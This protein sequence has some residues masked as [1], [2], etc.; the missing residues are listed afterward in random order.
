MKS[1]MGGIQRMFLRDK[2]MGISNNGELPEKLE[3]NIVEWTTLFLRN[4]NIYVKF[5]LGIPLNQYQRSALHDIGVSDT[6]FWRAARNGAKSFITGLA[7]ICKLMLYPNCW[8][9]VTAST[10]DQANKIVEDKIE[11]EIIKKLSP[12]LSYWLAKGWIKITKPTDGFRVENLLNNSVLNVMGPVPSSR[13]SRSNF[14]IYDEIATMKKADVDQIFEGMLY[15]RQPNYLVNNPK[16]MGNKRWL[17]ESKAIYLTSSRYKHQWWYGLWKD[18]VSGYYTDKKSKYN[19]FATDYFD[20]IENGLKTWGDFRRA[21]RTMNDFDFRMEM[22]NEAIGEAQDAF[23]SLKFFTDNQQL[24]E[25]FNPLSVADIYAGKPLSMPQKEAN[26]KRLVIA[27]LAFAGNSSY[28][29][30]DHTVFMCMSLHWK[31]FRFERHIDYIETRPGGGADK[32]VLRLKELFWQYQ[33]DYLIYDNKS[34]GETIYDYLSSKTSHP[35]LGVNWNDSGFT[36]CNESDIQIAREGK[37]EELRGRTVDKN[38]VP[39]LIPI[40]ATSEL[41]SLGWQNLRK[42]LEVN[43]IKF[44]LSMQDAQTM[45]ED[46][47]EYYQLTSEEL[48]QRL[49]PYGQTDMLIQECVN[50]SAEYRNGLVK[51]TEPRSGY[52]DRAVVLSY[53]NLIAERLDNRYAKNNKKNDIDLNNLQFVW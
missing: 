21:K 39:C 9:V 1:R 4:W 2:L 42:E 35:Q 12:Y 16:Y 11:K 46:N 36:V 7:A 3:E 47:G 37:I 17:E 49:L 45:L 28:Q 15:P 19:V 13:G 51:L 50:L 29:K 23:F 5:F 27:D 25:Y 8:I 22:L 32:V 34:G 10:V 48:V 31:D 6:F 24:K 40:I 30:N 20:N 43:N 41:N 33:A 26:E 38:A 44:L 52:K 14:T 53:G 18:C